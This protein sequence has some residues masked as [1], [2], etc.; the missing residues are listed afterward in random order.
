MGHVQL[1]HQWVVPIFVSLF[2][3]EVFYI[4]F[5]GLESYRLHFAYGSLCRV[6]AT[7]SLRLHLSQTSLI[8][9]NQSVM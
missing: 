8:S 6:S 3:L 2:S 9:L 1:L 4:G 7:Q 5:T